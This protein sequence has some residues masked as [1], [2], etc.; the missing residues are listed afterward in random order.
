MAL[1]LLAGAGG[2]EPLRIVTW[3]PGL[4]RDGPGLLL[5]DIRKGDAQARAAAQVIAALAPDVILLTCIDW[6]HEALALDAFAGLLAQTGHAMPHSFAARPNRGMPTGLDLDGDGRR[7]GAGDAQGFGRFSGQDSMAILSRL[8]LG[9]AVD[10]SAFLWRDLPGNLMPPTSAQVASV[11]RL[12]S[13]A[14]W[15]VAVETPQGPLHL[16]AWAATPPAFGPSDRNSRRNHDEATFWLHH[17]PPAPFVLIGNVNLDMADG[18]GRREALDALLEHA[19]D[20]APKGQWQPPQTGVNARHQGD[21]ALDTAEFSDTGP[22]NLRVDYILPAKGLTV[23]DSGVLWPAP[24]EPMAQILNRA[25]NHRPVWL[26]LELE[27]APGG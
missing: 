4:T 16:L 7:G 15:D 2:A 13:T 23:I 10:H 18:D 5:R 17:L 8:P 6:D 21:P 27:L 11:Q 14:H 20:S 1:G 9:P 12:S 19:R 26:D 24:E 25:S 22:G 3:D